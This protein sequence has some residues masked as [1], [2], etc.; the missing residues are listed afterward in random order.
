MIYRTIMFI[1]S[2]MTFVRCTAPLLSMPGLKKVYSKTCVKRPLSKIPKIV[3]QDQLSLNAG[4]KYCRRLQVEHSA[5]LL[6]FIKLPVVIKTFFLSIFAWPF[7]TGSTVLMY[8]TNSRV[9]RHTFTQSWFDILVR[10]R[11]WKRQLNG[12]D[13]CLL[14]YVLSSPMSS[15][16]IFWSDCIDVKGGPSRPTS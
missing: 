11:A 15:E 6:T 1:I 7:Y 16:W 2:D 13:Q 3:F 5:I 14:P 4:Q 10:V 12:S 8:I 9:T